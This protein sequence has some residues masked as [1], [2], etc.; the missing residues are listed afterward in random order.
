VISPSTP[1]IITVATA[2]SGA[3]MVAV[4]TSGPAA[5]VISSRSSL[6]IRSSG[7]STQ[8]S[9]VCF[10]SSRTKSRNSINKNLPPNAA[11]CGCASV[12]RVS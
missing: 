6:P 3:R 10:Y 8:D 9:E 7:R 1:E 2:V 4:S 12:I 11:I 5:M